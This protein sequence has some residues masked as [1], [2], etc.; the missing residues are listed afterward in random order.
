MATHERAAIA[1]AGPTLLNWPPSRGPQPKWMSAQPRYK[2]PAPKVVAQG[3]LLSPG[4]RRTD[5][6]PPAL[7]AMPATMPTKGR[8]AAREDKTQAWKRPYAIDLRTDIEAIST[9]TLHQA[10]H[11][12]VGID[13]EA[14]HG[15]RGPYA[16][17][18]DLPVRPVT[19]DLD[20]PLSL[21]ARVTIR[22]YRRWFADHWSE[23]RM[24][25][26]YVLWQLARVYVQIYRT[27]A[28]WGVWGHALG[29]LMFERLTVHAGV[30]SVDIG[31]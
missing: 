31:S 28:T 25:L 16:E 14:H 2:I 17:N 20:Y 10:L 30:G 24:D 7:K 15:R 1:Q 9:L 23:P 26:A 27:H 4:G 21:R 3:S 6:R 22:P 5:S 19:L 29:D 18:V 8:F 11:T 12:L 13:R